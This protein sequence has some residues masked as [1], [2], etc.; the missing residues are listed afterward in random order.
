[1]AGFPNAKFNLRGQSYI[2]DFK[3]MLQINEDTGK[4]RR[5]RPPKPWKVPAKALVPA[6]P[7][8]VINVT[9]GSAGTT[10]QIPHPGVKEAFI[11]V[12]VP[13]SAKVG[14]AMLVPV[15]TEA[16][17][18]E[19]K[20]ARD[21]KSGGGSTGEKFAAAVGGVAVGGVGWFDATLD[22]AGKGLDFDAA[23][24]AGDFIIY[25]F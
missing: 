7:T 5:I 23:E 25:L 15:P 9:G 13:A 1:M 16:W 22:A 11:S 14:Q 6:G 21:R 17:T 12:N 24:G 4:E 10:T 2:Y 3:K 18:A 8:A 20:P 19:G